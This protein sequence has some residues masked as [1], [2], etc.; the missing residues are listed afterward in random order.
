MECPNCQNQ[1]NITEAQY[2]ALYTCVHCQAVYFVGFDGQPQ[3]EANPAIDAAKPLDLNSA[4]QNPITMQLN[5]LDPLGLNSAGTMD[6][7]AS[8]FSAQDFS[9][10]IAL[11]PETTAPVAKEVPGKKQI[12]RA[13][14]QEA[15]VVTDE[16]LEEVLV[17][18]N[19]FGNSSVDSPIKFS[20]LIDGLD[21]KET[22]E[23]FI[24]AISDKK[25]GLV[26]EDITKKI[27][28]GRCEIQGL[29]P[30][31]AFVL[32]KRIQFLEIESTWSF[33]NAI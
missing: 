26:T 24:E 17:E 30:V 16:T 10:P 27:R 22:I 20:V 12:H 15:R 21:T 28:N 29:N 3:F 18:I 6:P 8:G 1:V 33:E 11:A 25:F 19:E 31:A 13:L 5:Q 14:P 2:G 7:N 9:S 32:A 23:N 4:E